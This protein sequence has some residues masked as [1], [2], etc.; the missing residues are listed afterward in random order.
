MSV[1]SDVVSSLAMRWTHRSLVVLSMV[2]G[3]ASWAMDSPAAGTPVYEATDQQKAEAERLFQ[4]A[5]AASNK[6]GALERYQASY[7]T[8]ASPNVLLMIGRTLAELDELEEAYTVFETVQAVSQEAINRGMTQYS[9]ALQSARREFDALRQR[10]ATVTITVLGAT[11]DTQMLVG[12]RPFPRERWGTETPVR[13]GDVTVTATA[14]SKPDYSEVFTVAVGAGTR[15]I[16]LATL[17]GASEAAPE[18]AEA[19]DGSH[20]AKVDFLGLDK[21]T[22]SYIAGG[23]GAA[24]FITFGVFGVLNNS[25]YNDLQD[26]C[27]NNIC[28]TNRSSDVNAGRTYQA[29]ANVGL[30]VG[31]V[32]VAA[33]T[34]LF[35]LSLDSGKEKPSTQVGIGPGSLTVGGT[36]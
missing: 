23:V 7:D 22:W 8:V 31:I 20:T 11:D 16:N 13:V 33:G 15:T 25:K 36:F 3:A 4:E 34:T 14:A 5:V 27:P 19:D 35:V 32:G 29:L 6:K 1:P 30:V 28:S 18:E 10:V 26:S 17:W 21:R 2:V 9:Q 24:G 12:G